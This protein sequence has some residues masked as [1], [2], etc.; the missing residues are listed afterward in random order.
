MP[1]E[2]FYLMLRL[3]LVTHVSPLSNRHAMEDDNTKI[4]IK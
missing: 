1:S 4:C 3:V 2:L